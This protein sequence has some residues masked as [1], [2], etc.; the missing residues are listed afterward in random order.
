MRHITKG[1]LKSDENMN[2]SAL[3]EVIGL[4]FFD[5]PPIAQLLWK[6]TKRIWL[7]ICLCCFSKQRLQDTVALITG[8]GFQETAKTVPIFLYGSNGKNKLDILIW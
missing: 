7:S 1:S 4:N 3:A 6:E 2:I 8:Q 5:K